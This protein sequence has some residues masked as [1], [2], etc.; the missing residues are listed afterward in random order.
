MFATQ[1][2]KMS[3]AWHIALILFSAQLKSCLTLP[4]PFNIPIFANT[5]SQP[6]DMAWLSNLVEGFICADASCAA[7]RLNSRFVM[8]GVKGS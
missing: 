4:Y 5:Y 2:N 6:I 1:P 3:A 8:E 7:V